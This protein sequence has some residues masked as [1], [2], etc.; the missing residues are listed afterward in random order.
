VI[1]PDHPDNF[2]LR[3][4]HQ[5][6]GA[7]QT[8]ADAA[9]AER[10]PQV[11]SSRRTLS[12]SRH[13]VD[14]IQESEQIKRQCR[15]GIKVGRNQPYSAM[16][17]TLNNHTRVL[18]GIALAC[19]IIAA[20]GCT[21]LGQWVNNGFKVGPNYE[22]PAGP[23]SEAWVD[24]ADPRVKSTP[25]QDQAWWT[26]FGDPALNGLIDTAH[27]QNL[28]LR[29]AGTRILEARARRNIAGGNL[30]PQSQS[31]VAGYAHAQLGKTLGLPLPHTLDLGAVGFNA[32]WELDFW[33][34]YRRSIEAA[35]ANLGASNESYGE[36]L[37][38]VLAEVATNYVQLRTFEQRLKFAHANVTIQK[39]SLEIAE[40]RFAQGAAAELDMLQARSNLAQTESLIPSLEIGRRLASNQ[41]CVLLGMSVNDLAG[42]LAPAVIPVAPPEVA[43]GIPADLLC[44]RPDVRR[45]E[46]EVAAQSAQIGIA[47]SDFYPH[48]GVNGFIGYAANDLTDLFGSKNFTGFII[49]SLQWNILNYGRI[50]NNV[51][52][53]DARLQA[54]TLQ[55]QKTVLTAGREVEDALVQFIQAQQQAHH[56][57][58]SV[59]DAQRS[60]ELVV[61]QFEGGIIDFN[62][63]YTTQSQL[64]VQQDQLA[65]T[66]GNIALALIQVY[67]SIGGGWESFLQGHGMPNLNEQAIV[68][69]NTQTDQ[70][71]PELPLTNE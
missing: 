30:F 48:L 70:E 39:K 55:Y 56:L 44:R 69:T 11:R 67:K 40:A 53:Q 4:L 19:L 61:K 33:G 27:Q 47:E 16:Q 3:S 24:Q 32:S 22:S 5:L 43:I 68:H 8:G 14:R 23:V 34:R 37:V 17:L 46:R 26:V 64:V 45:A 31:A 7:N 51:T 38:M 52:A 2:L 49:P 50:E 18:A 41:L 25:A 57:E 60:V 29:T 13:T 71:T 62:R 6:I 35:D 65:V 36:A 9:A 20:T 15:P 63:V 1:K 10:T 21:R 59:T 12:T 58:Q 28:D 54:A 66:R 42:Q